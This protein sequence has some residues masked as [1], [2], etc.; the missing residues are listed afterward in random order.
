MSPEYAMDGNFSIKSDVFSFGVMAL[1]IITGRKNKEFYSDNHEL[2]LLGNVWR[3]WQEGTALTLI[4]PSIGNS[5]TESEV[6]KCI[7]I[8]LLCV[9]ERAK[10]RPTISSV[11]LMLNS[12]APS[13]PKPKNPGFSVRKNHPNT[14]FSSMQDESW[15]VNQVSITI[16]DPR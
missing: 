13:M 16:F 9:Q 3:H 6:V 2:N 14:D 7:H 15:S 12:E 11:V 1:E 4:D 5:Y 8:G 10:D